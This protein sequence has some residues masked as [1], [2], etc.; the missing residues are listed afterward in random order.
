MKVRFHDMGFDSLKIEQFDLMVR[1]PKELSE[2]DIIYIL[3]GNPFLLLDEV[4][5]SR[6]DKVL[7]ELAFQDK[8]LMGYSAGSLLLGPSLE[9]MDHADSLL[10]F[11]EIELKK[12]DC[13]GLYNFHI[14]PHYA[15]FTNQVPELIAKI[16]EFENKADLPVYRINDNQGIIYK[17]G[18][19]R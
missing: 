16:N 1:D 12:L 2:F 15:D 4:M 18:K 5:K 8:I 17:D 10:G 7:K 3:G 9:L 11:N 14:F 6:A 19:L 13:L